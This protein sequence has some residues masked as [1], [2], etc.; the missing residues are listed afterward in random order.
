VNN[1]EKT[2]EIIRTA[3]SKFAAY[4]K[5]ILKYENGCRLPFCAAMIQAVSTS[6]TLVYFHQTIQREVPKN[7]HLHIRRRENLKSHI[8]EHRRSVCNPL[9]SGCHAR[10]VL[11]RLVKWES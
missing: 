1:D 4:A 10:F 8:L 6:E 3:E 7:S 5:N 9:N 2:E 11:M